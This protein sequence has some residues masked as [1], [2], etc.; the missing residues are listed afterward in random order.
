MVRVL[1]DPE[2]RLGHLLLEAS[3]PSGWTGEGMLVRGPEAADEYGNL[4]GSDL[5]Y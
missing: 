5:N 2:A 3:S 1:G 4:F